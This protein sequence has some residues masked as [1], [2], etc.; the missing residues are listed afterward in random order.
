MCSAQ[1]PPLL[2]SSFPLCLPFIKFS[3]SYQGIQHKRQGLSPYVKQPSMLET[4][5]VYIL[6]FFQSWKE[7]RPIKS[8]LLREMNI[9]HARF[10]LNVTAIA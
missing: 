10:Q 1:A 7:L 2:P 8:E 6:Y 4:S 3:L 9:L 5:E